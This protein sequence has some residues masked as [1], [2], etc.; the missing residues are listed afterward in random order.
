[1]A[2]NTIDTE[3]LYVCML[4][5]MMLDQNYAITVSSVFEPDYFE[6]AGMASVFLKVKAHVEQYNALPDRDIIINSIPED[7]R[8]AVQRL[9]T[10][11]DATDFDVAKN[12]DWL[13]EET[14]K[15]L[16]GRAIKDSIIKSVDVIDQGGNYEQVKNLV[17][18]ALCK[19][20]NIDLGLD[21]FGELNERLRRVIT[22]SDNRIK[23]YY[24]T[25]DELFNGGYPPY[26]L[27]M[28]I[29]KVHGHKTN[30]MTNVIA[31]QVKHGVKVALATLEMSED[32]YSQRFDA[33]FTNLDINRLYHNAAI[34]PRFLDGIKQV[35]ANI[36]D[37]AL[38]IKEY[39]TGQATVADFRRWLREL[40]MRGIEI[41]IL[42]C[43][44]ISLMK[45]EN[46]HAGDLYKD[47][48]AISEELRAL[49]FEFGIPVVTVAQ[50]NRAGTF[51]DF[52][53]LDMNSI[54]ESFGIPATA[55]SMLVQGADV[56]DMMYKNELKWKCVKNRLGGR[57]G[58][59]GKWYYDNR[60]LRIY[61]EMEMDQWI[62]DAQQSEDER[63]LFEREIQ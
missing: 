40:R 53:G 29:A 36:G 9:Y 50:I 6:D 57:V 4:K 49:G 51:M 20:I 54:G 28:M 18:T 2:E 59:I 10:E 44:Y 17:E 1:M 39:P 41:D 34:R 38:Y 30:I 56:E 62:A 26:T 63:A 61:D 16:K 13:R 47:G 37:G 45:A 25:L 46:N 22:A 15:Y 42:F 7:T 33:N 35:K 32:M 12:Y 5:G 60:S 14:N 8:P 11:A 58:L 24:P 43:D 21:Y 52:E 23:T 48:K 3:Y 19:D 27:N 31:R 55:D